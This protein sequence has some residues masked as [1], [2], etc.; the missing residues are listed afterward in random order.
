MSSMR[1]SAEIPPP[2]LDIGDRGYIAVD[3]DGIT[4]HGVSLGLTY[5]V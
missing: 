4:S 5:S 2:L 1:S 3:D